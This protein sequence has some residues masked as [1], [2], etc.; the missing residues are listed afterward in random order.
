M[1]ERATEEKET[2]MTSVL[3]ARGLGGGGAGLRNEEV[4]MGTRGPVLMGF[5]VFVASLANRK[6]RCGSEP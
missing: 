6:L 5:A 1:N 2:R 4:Q 3:R